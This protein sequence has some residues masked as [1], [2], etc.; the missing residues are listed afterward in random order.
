MITFINDIQHHIFILICLCLVAAL[1]CLAIP[2]FF[3]ENFHA[4][5]KGV[6]EGLIAKSLA[7]MSNLF[8]ELAVVCLLVCLC[9]SCC[10]CASLSCLCL[11]A[12]AASAAASHQG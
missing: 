1:N 8:D 2:S 7:N 5:L 12:C 4:A 6:T 11:C 10:C 3:A 9:C